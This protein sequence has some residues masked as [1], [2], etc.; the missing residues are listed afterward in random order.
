MLLQPLLR[1]FAKSSTIAIQSVLHALFLPTPFK[2]L[3]Q[4]NPGTNDG[5][6]R[7]EAKG[8]LIDSSLTDI[9]EE[10]LKPGA[11]YADC[12]VVRLKVPLPSSAVEQLAFERAK[13][14]D[15]GNGKNKNTETEEVLEIPDDG[16]FGGEVTGRLVWEAYEEALK[17]WEKANPPPE[18]TKEMAPDVD[19][20]HD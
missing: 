17:G 12:A 3:S 6:P 10:V 4:S 20:D 7:G 19:R 2:V 18:Q 8:G 11:L 14:K 5:K 16:E 13:N 15:K 9:P 1:I